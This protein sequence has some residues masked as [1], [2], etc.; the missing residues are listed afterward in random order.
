VVQK[1]RHYGGQE[2]KIECGIR[3]RE[4]VNAGSHR[5]PRIVGAIETIRSVES[6][7]FVDGRDVPLAPFDTFAVD[8][9]ASV[10]DLEFPQ[11]PI[12][13]ECACNAAT[14]TADIEYASSSA[15][16]A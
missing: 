13:G 3:M 6:E 12:E 15:E 1:V 16:Q 2:D 9:H 11:F 7:S 10:E 14:A 4:G 8:I 5:A